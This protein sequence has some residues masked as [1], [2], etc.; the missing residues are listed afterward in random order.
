MTSFPVSTP[1][2]EVITN[3]KLKSRNKKTKSQFRDYL[4][5]GRKRK[6]PYREVL[7]GIN[8]YSAAFPQINGYAPC[9]NAADIKADLVYPYTNGNYGLDADLYHY[10]YSSMF[11]ESAFRFEADKTNVYPNSY[12]NGYYLDSRQYGQP[13]IQYGNTYADFVGAAAKYGYDFSKYSYDSMN[14]SLD[15]GAKRY[16]SPSADKYDQ[17]GP[18]ADYN[19]SGVIHSNILTANNNMLNGLSQYP[20]SDVYEANKTAYHQQK[21]DPKH[22]VSVIQSP[23]V[24]SPKLSPHEPPNPA[25]L[26]SSPYSDTSTWPSCSKRSHQNSPCAA[27]VASPI[28][29]DYTKSRDDYTKKQD[30]YGKQPLSGGGAVALSTMTVPPPPPPH[31]NVSPASAVTALSVIQHGR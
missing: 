16:D 14:Y 9:Q 2:E 17:R 1:D 13:S 5:T 23:R 21:R 3:V 25:S 6:H 30:Q 26:H 27:S 18:G 4:H 11:P 22:A 12:T 19:K 24:A 20:V 31:N 10:P 7:T 8:G 29:L 28:D 15:I